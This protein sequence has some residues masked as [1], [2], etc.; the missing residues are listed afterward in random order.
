MC[1]HVR[2]CVHACACVCVCMRVCGGWMEEVIY[3]NEHLT[4]I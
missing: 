4:N 3:K 2:M 1:V